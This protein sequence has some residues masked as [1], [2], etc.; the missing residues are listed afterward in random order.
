MDGTNQHSI[1]RGSLFSYTDSYQVYRCPSDHR[2]VAG[3]PILRSYSMNN[4]MNGE[5]FANVANDMDPAHRLFRKDT[6][7]TRPSQLYIFL[8]EDP[9]TINDG[10]FVVYMN[11]AEGYQDHPA[12]RHKTGYP[13][14]FADGHTEIFKF[15][16]NDYDLAKL[17]Q[18]ATVAD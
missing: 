2:A 15:V 18:A 12:R 9:E 8:G 4:W 14:V 6:G 11:P 1:A 10:M 7:I 3:A 13:L 17:E 5:P 16:N